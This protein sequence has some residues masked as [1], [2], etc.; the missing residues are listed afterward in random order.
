MAGSR[1]PDASETFSPEEEAIILE[2]ARRMVVRIDPAGQGG[3]N[4]VEVPDFMEKLLIFL[5]DTGAHISVLGGLRSS[6]LHER[7]REGVTV[8]YLTW[9]RPKNRK[10][11]DCPVSTRL[12]PWIAEWL[13]APRPRSRSRYNQLLKD[14]E[15]ELRA[16][17][18]LIHLNP[19]RFRHRALARWHKDFH[20]PVADVCRI[21]GTTVDTL[22]KYIQDPVDRIARDL[23]REGW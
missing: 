6:N 18:R 17:G 7:T 13:D 3:F 22:V 8:R 12:D 10:T 4:A 16:H 15:A 9:K 14:L 20:R 1:S 2:T 5:L 21:G 23:K 11:I 19:H